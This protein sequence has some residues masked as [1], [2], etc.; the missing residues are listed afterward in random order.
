VYLTVFIRY[1]NL[2]PFMYLLLIIEYAGRILLGL[3]KPLVVSHIPPGAFGDYIM[4]PLA[5]L[6]L[7]LSLK[8]PNKKD[9][10]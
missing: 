8:G 2:I 10:K 1:R 5:S 3:W 9:P 6:M 4:V 7:I